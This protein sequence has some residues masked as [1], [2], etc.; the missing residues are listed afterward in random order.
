MDDPAQDKADE[1]SRDCHG[2]IMKKRSAKP[3]Q[4]HEL[5]SLFSLF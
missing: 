1:Q 3:G 4:K 2:K 5:P